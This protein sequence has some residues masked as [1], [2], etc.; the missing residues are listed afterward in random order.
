MPRCGL[1]HGLDAGCVCA[2]GVQQVVKG[3]RDGVFN[4]HIVTM[5]NGSVVA[6]EAGRLCGRPLA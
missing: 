3:S 2:A 4:L 6:F 1:L 5:T